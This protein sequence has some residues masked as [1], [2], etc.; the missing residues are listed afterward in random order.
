MLYGEL[1]ATKRTKD[2]TRTPL[3]N[4][5]P[6]RH[7]SPFVRGGQIVNVRA[8]PVGRHT[9]VQLG[10]R[11]GLGVPELALAWGH[12][13]GCAGMTAQPDTHLPQERGQ[14]LE[15]L[16][17]KGW[18]YPHALGQSAVRWPQTPDTT[19]GQLETFW[20]EQGDHRV[21]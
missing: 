4:A 19:G 21:T 7:Q 17:L 18:G 9:H 16:A 13:V 6:A 11:K 1:W 10:V 5:E 12:E 14:W 8:R 20:G 3:D 15:R 2:F